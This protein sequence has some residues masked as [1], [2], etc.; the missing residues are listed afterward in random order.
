VG[1]GVHTVIMDLEDVP[2]IDATG[3]VAMEST[4]AR[5]N[6]HGIK[7]VLSGV[8]PQPRQAL[9]KAGFED[10]PDLLEITD[11]TNTTLNNLMR[12]G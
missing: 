8:K 2:A 5:L 1:Q 4:I 12:S 3:L 10:K 9:A 11:D 7:V 6:G